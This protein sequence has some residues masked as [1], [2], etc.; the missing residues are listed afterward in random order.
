[1]G[2]PFNVA[3]AVARKRSRNLVITFLFMGYP[4][5][6]FFSERNQILPLMIKIA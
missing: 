4:S 6:T 1:M 3:A 2:M 5:V